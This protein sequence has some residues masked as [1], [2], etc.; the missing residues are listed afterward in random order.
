MDLTTHYMGLQLKNP[1]AAVSP[2]ARSTAIPTNFGPRGICTP[3][4][5]PALADTD[6]GIIDRSGEGELC[7][8]ARLSSPF[9]PPLRPAMCSCVPVKLLGLL[10]IGP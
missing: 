10:K 7:L 9:L 8:V 2:T 1:L 3:I 4:S 6:I 5:L